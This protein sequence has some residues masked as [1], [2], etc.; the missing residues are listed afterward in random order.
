MSWKGFNSWG[1][2]KGKPIVKNPAI[3]LERKPPIPLSEH[4]IQLDESRFVPDIG[5]NGFFNF[6]QCTG[7]TPSI[8]RCSLVGETLLV[9]LISSFMFVGIDLVHFSTSYSIYYAILPKRYCQE[10]SGRN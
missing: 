10:L 8:S 2:K 4:R 9:K 6:K 1:K 3:P 5:R 7:Q